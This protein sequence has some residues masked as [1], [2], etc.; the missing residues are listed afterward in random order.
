MLSV[1]TGLVLKR[2]ELARPLPYRAR[3]IPYFGGESPPVV[4]VDPAGAE[5][6]RAQRERD[7]KRRSPQSSK[8]KRPP[9]IKV[10]RK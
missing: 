6:A 2:R 9:R 3:W 7:K 10:R 8:P 4:P 1:Y 5:A